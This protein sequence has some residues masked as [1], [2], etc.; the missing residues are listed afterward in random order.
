MEN[1]LEISMSF[2][3]MNYL[4]CE[5]MKTSG[6]IEDI[7]IGKMEELLCIQKSFQTSGY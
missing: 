2:K 6:M 5:C 4:S 7:M 1:P 3:S